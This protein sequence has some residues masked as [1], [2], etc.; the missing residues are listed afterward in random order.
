MRKIIVFFLLLLPICAS[1]QKQGRLLIDSLNNRLPTLADD[2]NKVKLLNRLSLAYTTIS[3]DLGIA[4]ATEALVLANKIGY[5]VGK[6]WAY[7]NL[8]NNFVSKSEYQKALGTD[9]LSVS[10]FEQTGNT[11]GMAAAYSNI[12]KVYCHQGNPNLALGFDQKALTIYGASGNADGRAWVLSDLVSVYYSLALYNKA[13]EC[14]FTSLRLFEEQGDKSGVARDFKYIGDCYN[15]LGNGKKAM[16]WYFKSLKINEGLG[17]KNGIARNL[18]AIGMIYSASGD[19]AKALEYKFKALAIFQELGDRYLTTSYLGS[20]GR[21]YLEIAKTLKQ[22]DKQLEIMSAEKLGNIHKSL[23]YNFWAL[24]TGREIS[25]NTFLAKSLGTIGEAY[26]EIAKSGCKKI[27]QDSLI[28][29]NCTANLKNAVSY[30]SQSVELS[31]L[32]KDHIILIE[33]SPSLGEALFRTGDFKKSYDMFQLFATVKD[34]VYSTQNKIKI[35]NLETKRDLELKEK[36]I[37]IKNKQILINQ[38]EVERKKNERI[39][40]IIGIALLLVIIIFVLRSFLQQKNT[41]KLISKEKQRS[42]DLLLNILPEEVAEELKNK[43]SADAKLFN[44]VTVIFTDFVGFTRVAEKMTPQQLVGE[45]D[46]CFKAFDEI[47]AKY[48]IE[49]IK[50]I[51]DAYLAVSGLPMANEQHAQN[52]V[53]AALEMRNFMAARQKALGEMSFQIRLGV[54]SGSVVAGIVGVKKF[55]YDIW[56]DTVNTANLMEQNSNPSEINI[57]GATYKIIK[58]KYTCVPS[59]SIAAQNNTRIDMY[60]V[61]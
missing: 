56:G 39:F 47:S 21:T 54:H 12:A 17:D 52:A 42:D 25:A 11:P 15:L 46:A 6:G 26:L 18:E 37:Q 59:G 44:D 33:H 48:N 60:F 61:K 40:Y 22:D 41:N 53:A 28:P 4:K 1:A 20:I 45:L 10:I 9:S 34:S 29:N 24:K 14:I 30:L 3:P 16:E 38:L 35:A 57:S 13:M 50:T 36:D 23:E 7:N 43:G 51:G 27:P 19:F 5:Q 55:A 49:K 8:G 32:I 31:K 58:D 2:T